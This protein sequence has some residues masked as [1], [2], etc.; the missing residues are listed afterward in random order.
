M[1]PE[2]FH[3]HGYFADPH[4]G[5]PLAGPVVHAKWMVD[6]SRDMTLDEAVL[7]ISPDRRRHYVPGGFRLNGLSAP[8]LLWRLVQ[9]FEPLTRE[10]SVVHDWLCVR[11]EPWGYGAWVFYH[12][13]RANGVG[14]I[15]AWIRWAA[16][17]WFGVWF[18]WRRR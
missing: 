8:R 12:A 7:F 15:R 9:P 14:P 18:C 17:R 2:S 4:S 11:G 13:M 5:I 3:P 1:R 10:A 6:G 16:V